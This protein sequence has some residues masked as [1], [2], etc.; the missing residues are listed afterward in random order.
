MAQGQGAVDV[1]MVVCEICIYLGEALVCDAAG[2]C[3]PIIF[4]L[5][6]LQV[7]TVGRDTET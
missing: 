5:P 3:R 1:V 2:S 4:C 7:S 6:L